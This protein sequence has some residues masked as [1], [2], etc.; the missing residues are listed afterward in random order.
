MMMGEKLG[1]S[2]LEIGILDIDFDGIILTLN[3]FDGFDTL[4]LLFWMFVVKNLG[5]IKKIQHA[6]KIRL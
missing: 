3:H 1:M 4:D 2:R 6:K 5:F